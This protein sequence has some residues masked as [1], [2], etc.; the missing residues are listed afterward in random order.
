MNQKY[1]LT[2]IVILQKDA[3][4]I[5]RACPVSDVD[6]IGNRAYSV[7]SITKGLAPSGIGLSRTCREKHPTLRRFAAIPK[8]YLRT[9]YDQLNPHSPKPKHCRLGVKVEE[10][11]TTVQ[12]TGLFSTK[13]LNNIRYILLIAGGILLITKHKRLIDL[14]NSLGRLFI[15]AI[16]Y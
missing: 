8:Y 12:V 1:S 4:G 11:L 3:T 6:K 14:A 16:K 15:K 5:F 7:N 13:R 9:L 2:S 10:S